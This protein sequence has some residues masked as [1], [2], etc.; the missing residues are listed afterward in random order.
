MKLFDV[1]EK[2]NFDEIEQKNLLDVNVEKIV[3]NKSY[4]TFTL[5]LCSKELISYELAQRIKTIFKTEVLLKDNVSA[6]KADDI[7]ITLKLRYDLSAQYSIQSIYEL[8]K[9]NILKEMADNN[10]LLYAIFRNV[11]V[12]FDDNKMII[13]LMK[14]GLMDDKTIELKKYLIDLFKYKYDKTIDI[15]FIENDEINKSIK[16][17]IVKENENKEY[18]YQQK[19]KELA[20]NI[21]KTNKANER[22]SLIENKYRKFEFYDDDS[23]IFGKIIE[24][25]VEIKKIEDITEEEKSVVIKGNIISIDYKTI[26]KKDMV[27][28]TF[29]VTDDTSSITAQIFIRDISQHQK[30]LEVSRKRL[31]I[32]D[33]VLIKGSVR[34]IEFFHEYLITNI[35]SIKVL[36]RKKVITIK[37]KGKE[38]TQYIL[39]TDRIDVSLE[40]R[41]EFHLH[42]KYSDNDA[43]GAVEDY[44]EAANKFG[45]KA[46]A[47]TDHGCVQGLADA[48]SYKNSQKFNDFKLINGV[49]A[50]L[51]D[52]ELSTY[53]NCEFK[54]TDEKISFDDEFIIVDILQSGTN[55]TKDKI[56]KINALKI[57][58]MQVIERFSEFADPKM[59]LSFDAKNKTGL[60]DEMLINK[61][62]EKELLTRFFEF[63]KDS[64]VFVNH[65][66]LSSIS[67]LKSRCKNYGIAFDKNILDISTLA[68][69]LNDK[70]KKIKLDNIVKQMK[71]KNKNLL[72]DDDR[73][74]ALKDIFL[75][76]TNK[77][78]TEYEVH[79][80]NEFQQKFKKDNDYIKRLNY[81]HIILLAKN[82]VGRVNLY[83]LV[84]D[85]YTH[86]FYK[87]PRMPRSLINKYREGLIVG[88]AC[89]AG[90]LM[91]AV[92]DGK[93][94]DE[95]IKIASY[96]DYLE[97]QPAMN[98][99]FLFDKDNNNFKTVEDLQNLNKKIV[100][101]G[102]LLNKPVLATCDSH[103][104]DKEDKIFR[105][106]L[107][108]GETHK[109]TDENS[110]LQDE[111]DVVNSDLVATKN[112][113]AGDD[114]ISNEELYFR[115]TDE[116]LR[117]F[118]YL[119][120][121][122]AY[123]V[124]IKNT[125]L[126]NDM[127]ENDIL[128]IRL[129]KCPPVIE[130]SDNELRTACYNKFQEIYGDNPPKDFK[131]RLDM[132]L[133]MI[134][135]NG[136]SVMYI[137]AKRIIDESVRSGY[138]VGSRGSVGSSFAATMAGISEVNP[139]PPHY[140]CPHCKHVEYNTEETNQYFNAT[141]F[142]MPDKICPICGK[143]MNK[144]GVNIPFETFLGVPGG[145]PKEPDIDLNFATE[146]QSQAHGYTKK[147]FGEDHVFKAG[148][149]S[150]YKGRNAFA[151]VKQYCE[152]N[153]KKENKAEKNR[154]TNGIVRV[155]KTTGQHPG[156][157]IVVPDDEEIYT[158][159]PI[160]YPGNKEDKG[161]TT[162]FD[163]HKID[164]NL[165]KLD[166]LG[167]DTPSIIKR[168]YDLTKVDPLTVKFYDDKVMELFK[169]TKSIGIEPKDI[170]GLSLGT[171]SVPEF[172]TT[173]AM[174]TLLV[175]KPQTVADLIRISGLSH[176]E[177][178]WQG[179]AEELIKN[180]IAK[181][182]DCVCCRD[183][184]M[185]YL[186]NKGMD[187]S[188][189]FSIS[190]RVR[191]GNGLTSDYVI[192]MEDLKV[193]DWYIESCEKIKYMFPKAHAAAYVITALRIAYYKVYF[194]AE[195]YAA[196]FSV[197]TKHLD[198]G[199]MCT[200]L[201]N[202]RF[203][204][205]KGKLS[206][207][208]NNEDADEENDFDI[209]DSD[210]QGEDK[211]DSLMRNMRITEEML[212]R[213][214]EWMPLDINKAKGTDF[215]VID[216]KVMPS[217]VSITGL[218][219]KKALQ[220]EEEQQKEPFKSIKDFAQRTRVS[221][222]ILAKMKELGIFNDVPESNE[223]DLLSF[224]N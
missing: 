205:Q 80:L 194:P 81:Y 35:N 207:D 14:L 123:E 19:L 200:T 40:K 91:D 198:Y 55:L 147:I 181:L 177:N 17:I 13:T 135:K 159:V 72:D 202:V 56:I 84:S 165:L 137:S 166:M 75:I 16:E 44:I 46:M 153:S 174:K 58:N 43:V 21:E 171:L 164:E 33:V 206:A 52:D 151:Y 59:P 99:S 149:I 15:E 158:F 221:K 98:N 189:A 193:P 104:V 24:Q 197:K 175:A 105:T 220:I 109:K 47:I 187:K 211:G 48:Y 223:K 89:I 157:M 8:D 208:A 97:I 179:N 224:L 196:F 125:N 134:I 87:R 183:D 66:P 28:I 10:R 9:E 6:V 216:G 212:S 127:I 122:K 113:E 148:T 126:I 102:V 152:E 133:D 160:Q 185:L 101:L 210:T 141:A 31:M 138:L 214:I 50:Y 112:D 161:L 129:D 163:Y 39:T 95:L 57:K 217:F 86:Y 18:I 172:G 4:T 38:A 140:I 27:I 145:K 62:D 74:D 90:E 222:T 213:G 168:L 136:Y 124:V 51:V 53:M 85:S 121:D 73:L 11:D 42:T 218:G 132:E 7:I 203:N 54:E 77:L 70:I 114:V 115:T 219:E 118:A 167:H 61:Q 36:Q 1:I 69:T 23:N 79:D 192:A 67:F 60:R 117:E 106:I 45:M 2:N 215:R 170:G 29:D 119:G 116:M 199:A 209:D 169:S 195:Y 41:V 156:G 94:D 184:I 22:K 191:K 65:I 130:N 100:E 154:L 93:D 146:Y 76:L 128:P 120:E 82:D 162:H 3:S 108:Y 142:D 88:S 144:D 201:E 180:N 178:V 83:K 32:G 182:E 186:S 5:F 78:K 143:E 131:D 34:Y 64:K 139:L 150:T 190:E 103:Y 92:K 20:D 110:K 204:L 107:K 25:D 155:K 96:Y 71:I 37:G 173:T 68:R 176:G 12:K 30:E 26:E 111:K 188:L 49:E 63:S